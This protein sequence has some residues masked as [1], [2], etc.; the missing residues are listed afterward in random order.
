VGAARD[1]TPDILDQL[2]GVERAIDALAAR[3]AEEGFMLV[4]EH[5]H[6]LPATD[7]PI[8]DWHPAVSWRPYLERRIYAPAPGKPSLTA[9]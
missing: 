2:A 4:I 9:V 5:I 1:V 6:N 3:A 7:G 8:P